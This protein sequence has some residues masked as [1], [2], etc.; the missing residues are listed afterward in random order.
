MR[1]T[2]LAHLGILFAWAA[3]LAFGQGDD[4]AAPEVPLA[5]ALGHAVDLTKP[6]ERRKAAHELAKR[7][8][9]T[10][11]EWLGVCEDFAPCGPLP[12]IG[13]STV[14]E[15]LWVQGR[16][17]ACEMVLY[18]PRELDT[19]APAPLIL[20]LHGAGG[21]G[22]RAD[23]KWDH[24]ADRIGAWILAPSEP[25]L[26]KGFAGTDEERQATLA[27]LRWMRRQVNVDENAVFIDG[28]SRGG[29]LTWDLG[30]RFPDRWAGMAPHFSGPRFEL[31]GGQNNMRYLENLMHMHLWAVAGQGEPGSVGWNVAEAVRRLKDYGSTD[32][33]HFGFFPGAVDSNAEGT[34][35]IDH[36]SVRRI[37]DPE[38]SV[39]RA[40]R[41]GGGRRGP[42]EIRGLGRRVKEVF[43]PV[44]TDAQ[45]KE[46]DAGGKRQLII[47]QSIEKTARAELT[48]R[49]DGSLELSTSSVTKL[50]VFVQKERID[51]VQ[52]KLAV[53]LNGKLR[54]E[55]LKPSAETLL[56]D[57]VER[58]DRTFRPV[59]EVK[60]SIR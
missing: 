2:R 18:R 57:F 45:M 9:V 37:A 6:S 52:G 25:G 51:A 24:I 16:M 50:R 58:F 27:A 49:E 60:L 54:K 21:D 23:G 13:R 14:T 1:L 46:L 33:T 26:N 4:A 53:R 5:D 34:G 47:D 32:S 43:R 55:R 42:L 28:N 48:W 36:F 15:E 12:A 31:S 3:S 10:I 22:H 7:P 20:T 56:K 38:H 29:H 11:E 39:L 19:S 44:F 30:A 40:A 41:L 59:A 8:G 35:W 17:V